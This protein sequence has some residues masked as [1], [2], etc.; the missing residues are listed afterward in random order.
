M[1]MIL[2][3]LTG[4]R[5][6]LQEIQLLMFQWPS[7]PSLAPSTPCQNIV[8]PQPQVPVS[9]DSYDEFNITPT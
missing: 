3:I 4:I 9:I 1:L 8:A 6:P 7:F 5:T 2:H